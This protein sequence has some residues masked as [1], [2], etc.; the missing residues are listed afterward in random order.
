MNEPPF[1]AYENRDAMADAVA[2][3]IADAVREGHRRRGAAGL[4]LSGGSTPVATYER[5]AGTDLP[6]KA[7]SVTLAD[8]RWV[9]PDHPASNEALLRRTLLRGP[10]SAARLI[11][12]KTDAKTAAEGEDAVNRHL[13]HVPWPADIVLLGMGA[14][15]HTASLF[16]H[17]AAL[18]RALAP[19]AGAR[20]VALVPDPLPPEAPFERMTLTLPAL[21]DATRILLLLA[22][23]EKRATY[24]A[25][26]AGDDIE[27]MPVRAILKQSA[28]PVEVHWAP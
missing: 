18:A 5:L 2:R 24:E 23:A 26:L 9:D 27:E 13:V 19:A 21:L 16:P 6:W 7:V 3:I 12:L 22:G 20:A 17:A 4:V 8:E 1:A 28:V 10:A 14:D 15:G 25:A 11:G